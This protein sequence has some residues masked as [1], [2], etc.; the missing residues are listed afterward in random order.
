MVHRNLYT[1]SLPALQWVFLIITAWLKNIL[2]Q[3][4]QNFG[5]W[6]WC[7]PRKLNSWF[8]CIKFVVLRAPHID[9]HAKEI[10][11]MQ[12][13]KQGFW[14]QGLIY[15]TNILF[16]SRGFAGVSFDIRFIHEKSS[17]IRSSL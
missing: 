1:R 13:Y 15:F 16:S 10:W 2:F 17:S 7:A 11:R 9:G 12:K 5:G 4:H 3:F 14:A 6:L 8:Q